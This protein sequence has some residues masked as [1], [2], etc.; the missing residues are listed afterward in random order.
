MERE[1]YVGV[2]LAIQFGFVFE[3]LLIFLILLI[4]VV[5]LLLPFA[6]LPGEG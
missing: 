2:Q 5:G 6:T 1:K 4:G 3:H